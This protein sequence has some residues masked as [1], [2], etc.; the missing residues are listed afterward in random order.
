[1]PR[2]TSSN[3]CSLCRCTLNGPN[4]WKVNNL[5]AP[6]LGT[7]WKPLEW[8]SWEGKSP[9]ELFSIPGVSAVTVALD[10]MHNKYLGVDQYVFG[11]VFYILCFMVLPGEPAKNLLTCWSH[12]KA[13]YQRHR[14]SNQFASITKL[15]MFLRKGGVIK[16]RG[17][18]G[19]LRGLGPAILD[20]WASFMNAGLEI[21][22]KIHLLLKLHCKLEDL[23]ALHS[24]KICLP[25]AQ[26][27]KA[28]EYAFSMTELQSD[29]FCF[30]EGQEDCSKHLFTL[31]GKNHMLLHS[32]LL[33]SK[34][35]PWRVWCFMGEDF[36][37]KIQ[38]IGEASVRGLKATKV[39]NKMVAHYR[40]GLHMQLSSHS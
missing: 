29:I 5:Q 37:R 26:A 38:K 21:H 30:F 13:Y 31:T 40:L 27:M 32:V 28:V 14:T 2:S 39:S 33:S 18:A 11:S 23:F 3:P 17:K 24:E 10:W 16:L 4:S 12:I 9:C 34:I 15:S 35:H 1:L 8:I 25:P 20:L 7:L 19:E 22:C 6:W 36:M